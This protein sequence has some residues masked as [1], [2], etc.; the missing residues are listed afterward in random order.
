MKKR[1]KSTE[2]V[3][4]HRGGPEAQAE[5]MKLLAEGWQLA[6]VAR[7][8]KVRRGTVRDWRDSPAGQR[9]LAAARAERSA[10]LLEVIEDGRRLLRENAMRAVQVLVD[11]LASPVPFEA[12]AAAAQLLD[13]VGLPRTER[14]ETPPKPKRDLSK[15]ST[16][17]LVQL[18]ALREKARA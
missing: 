9:L 16:E 1:P 17:E 10:A 8:L 12:G 7:Q 11:K 3:Q 14:I 15:L 4:P 13:R 5:A 2:S 6:S 18:R